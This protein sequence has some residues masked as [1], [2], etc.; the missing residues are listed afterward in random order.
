MTAAHR[1]A[2]PH[3]DD[4][5]PTLPDA[6]VAAG[7][8]ESSVAAWLAH[9]V[10]LAGRQL[11]VWVRDYTTLAQSLLFPALTMI[12]FTVVLGDVVSETTGQD[13]A[14][15]TVPLVILVGA[16]FGSMAAAVRLNR[17][18]GTGLLARL[19]V[20]P[21]HRAADLSARIIAELVRILVATIVLLIAGLAIGFRFTQ[22]VGAAIGI[23]GV[24]LLYGMSF[25]M[26]VLA[27]AVNARP[28]GPIV[29]MISLLASVMM[30]FN[31]GFSPIEAYP[32]WLQPIV[33]NQPMTPAI[34]VMRSLATGG[35]I[36]ENL[37][38]VVIWAVA[39]LVV[40]TW[41]ALRGY[42]RAA[43]NR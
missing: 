10:I 19:Y 33:T 9:T 6:P 8:R 29:P 36:T 5:H 40:F 43:T 18:R 41:P 23:V 13:S 39:L 30:F 27:L 16:M 26:A 3:T 15:G 38:K 17:E 22:G 14:F 37:V 42:R 31:S 1:A 28:G 24:A 34:E 25:S 12:M 2:E 20:L 32:Q 7:P 11:S 21:I 4:E 35:P